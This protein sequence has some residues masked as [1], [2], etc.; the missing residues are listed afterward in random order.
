MPRSAPGRGFA[1]GRESAHSIAAFDD[2]GAAD[3]HHFDGIEPLKAAV[4]AQLP[5]ASSVLVKGSRFMQME[6]VVRAI[7][8]IDTPQQQ[9]KEAG[10]AA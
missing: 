1:L 4:L 10:H 5:R 2:T 3:A 9:D 8:A 6:R 7:S